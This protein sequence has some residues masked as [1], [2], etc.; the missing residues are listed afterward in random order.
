MINHIKNILGFKRILNLFHN[1]SSIKYTCPFC[2]YS[3]NELS[4]IGSDIPVLSE[5]QVVG[6][7]VRQAGCYRCGSTDRDRLIFIYLKEKIRIF[8][9]DKDKSILHIAPEK[10]LSDKLLEFH[11]NNYVCGDLFTEGFEYP[12][13]VQNMDIRQIPFSDDT[14]DLIICNHVLE[15]IPND[16]DAMKELQRVLKIGGQAILQVPISKNSLVTFEDFSITD[17]KQRLETFG[18]FDHVRI[19]GQDYVDRL[20]QSGFKV[21]RL[22]ISR[23]FSRFGLNMDEDIFIGVK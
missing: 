9:Q 1:N 13:H 19:Y 21:N 7:G 15:H 4:A 20:T 3:S 12:G 2:N 18:Q 22:N 8:N 11:F 23:E 6:G 17:P 10:N 16:M 5:K 14:F